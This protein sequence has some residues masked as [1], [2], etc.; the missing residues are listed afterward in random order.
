[1]SAIHQ[2]V[3]AKRRG[4]GGVGNGKM[5]RC[6]SII[7]QNSSPAPITLTTNY[8]STSKPFSWRFS[9]TKSK[10]PSLKGKAPLMQIRRPY[11]PLTSTEQRKSLFMCVVGCIGVVSRPTKPDA[12]Q[13]VCLSICS[14]PWFHES[15]CEVDKACRV[16]RRRSG[17]GSQTPFTEK[18]DSFFRSD[19]NQA[20]W[21]LLTLRVG[22]TPPIFLLKRSKTK[23]VC[24][25]TSSSCVWQ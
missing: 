13:L 16:K 18:R 24:G 17:S 21:E 3:R 2:K 5:V 14:R 25:W 7:I 4:A 23:C 9:R 8:C 20:V 6:Q 10:P 11:L 1:M 22:S 19:R 12:G 15:V